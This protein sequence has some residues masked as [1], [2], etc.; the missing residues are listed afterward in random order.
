MEDNEL[1]NKIESMINDSVFT[2]WEWGDD[3]DEYSVERVNQTSLRDNLF[4]F[5][6]QLLTKK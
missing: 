5:I 2:D 3:G 4:E 1:K 6:K